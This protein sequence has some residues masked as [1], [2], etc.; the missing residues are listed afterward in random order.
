LRTVALIVFSANLHK[1]LEHIGVEPE[2]ARIAPARGP[3]LWGDCA[4]QET[5]RV[6]ALSQ[7]GIRQINHRPTAPTISTPLGKFAE[8]ANGGDSPAG[9]GLRPST[10][11]RVV[12]GAV[13]KTHEKKDCHFRGNPFFQD[14]SR[15]HTRAHAVEMP[16]RYPLSTESLGTPASSLESAP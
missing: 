8:L 16:T 14:G 4:A 3:P 1:I 7:T 12:R 5:G 9:A 10:A 2:A 13:A 11:L 6:L 15:C